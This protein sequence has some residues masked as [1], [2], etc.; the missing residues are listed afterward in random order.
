M[1]R[2]GC[3]QVDRMGSVM[4]KVWGAR[5]V[6]SLCTLL[7]V[8]LVLWQG[9]ATTRA[10]GPPPA[11]GDSEVGAAHLSPDGCSELIINGGFRGDRP[12]LGPG[13]YGAA[14]ELLDG[15]IACG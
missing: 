13:G 4:S 10:Q 5:G 14:A 9:T 11:P 1:P 3:I 2:Q 8:V 7:A 6:V 12:A 15:T